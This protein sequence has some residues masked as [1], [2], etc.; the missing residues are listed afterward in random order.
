MKLYIYLL[1]IFISNQSSGQITTTNKKIDEFSITLKCNDEITKD[2][3]KSRS[4]SKINCQIDDVIYTV[5]LTEYNNGMYH[6]DSL[7]NLDFDLDYSQRYFANNG[8]V[9]LIGLILKTIKGYPGKEY[10]FQYKFE[11]KINFRRIYIIKNYL[12]ELIYEGP[13]SKLYNTEIDEFFNSFEVEGFDENQTPYIKMPS[14][15]EIKNRPFI[16]K[17]DSETKQIIE[18]NETE[19]GKVPLIIELCETKPEVN[20]GVLALTVLYTDFPK[21]LSDNNKKDIY[22][23]H[24]KTQELTFPNFRWIEITEPTKDSMVLKYEYSIHNEKV[25]DMRKVF[26]DNNRMYTVAGIGT[27]KSFPNQRIEDFINEFKLK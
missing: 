14:E 7:K 24:K 18:A 3:T 26:F 16:A 20:N 17:F 12:V 5:K 9:D 11:D 19:F 6:S 15:E 2:E 22:E 21:E 13:K 10:R 25:I 23:L 27:K 8:K 4:I 1:I